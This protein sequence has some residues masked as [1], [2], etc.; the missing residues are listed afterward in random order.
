VVTIIISDTL[1]VGQTVLLKK[2]EGEEAGEKPD[3]ME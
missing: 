2:K 3:V 1:E